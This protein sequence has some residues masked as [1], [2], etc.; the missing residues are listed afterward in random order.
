MC[1]TFY[2][3]RWYILGK[4]PSYD[5]LKYFSC[6]GKITDES[7]SSANKDLSNVYAS[8]DDVPPVPFCAHFRMLFDYCSYYFCMPV[9][10]YM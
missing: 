8:Y 3:L 1:A 9:F 10:M 6:Q 4:V 2:H 5:G 7:K